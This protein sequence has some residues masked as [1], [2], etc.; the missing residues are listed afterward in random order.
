MES[1]V[2][3]FK[4][5]LN[6][7]TPETEASQWL[8]QSFNASSTTTPITTSSFLSLLS[9]PSD[10][11]VIDDN[12][13]SSPTPPRTKRVM[14][15][16]TL[17]TTVQSR[18][19]SFLAYERQRFCKRDLS[20]L[21]RNVLSGNQ[22]LDF[23]VKRAARNLLDVLSESNYEW[24]SCLSLDSGEEGVDE[25]FESI[26]G[27]LKEA[28]VD[29]N[30]VILPW[31]PI[32]PDEFCSATPFGSCE[33]SVDSSKQ[34]GE[35]GKEEV[36]EVVAEMEIDCPANVPLDPGIHEKATCLK[37]RIMNFEYSLKTVGLADE[38]RQLCLD[39]G[40]DSF[41]VLG[42]IEP[43][44]ADD[45][46]ASVLIS[47]LV[48]ESEEELGWPSQVLCSVILPKLLLLE[49]PA[50]RVLV[51]AIMEYCKL[52]PKAAV[53]ALLFP[54]ILRSEGINNPIC[55]VITRI[56]RE[57]LHPAH[58]SAFCQKLLCG[59]KD[60]RRLICLPCHQRLISGELV[61]TESLF[62]LFQ[63]ILNHNVRLTQDSVDHIVYQV[64]QLAKIFSKS[65]KFGHFLL[66]LVTKCSP[67]L[68]SH[69]LSLIEAVENTSTLV[70][71]SVLSKLSSL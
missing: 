42:L 64:Q 58:V 59:E 29:A 41:V 14:F 54:L 11:I 2:P 46:T 17:P 48:N 16:E 70:T 66:C 51:A 43:W 24:I 68:K 37:A 44:L 45:E 39:K 7:P 47:H 12:D 33:V 30:D 26:P 27:W 22:E 40:R 60:E 9:K 53:Y 63:I 15:I 67:L 34:D 23:W 56:T 31:L 35:D 10:A 57:C 36:N 49:V 6:S 69:K 4:I 18:I 21:A 55:D 65:L 13:S 8:Q 62:N 5:F 1:W 61:W 50:S 19:L 32:L 71:K 28:A 38:I 25:E 20:R 3:L 52:H